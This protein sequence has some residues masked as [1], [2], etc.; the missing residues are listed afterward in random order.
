MIFIEF[1][2]FLG[3]GGEGEPAGGGRRRRR[4]ANLRTSQELGQNRQNPYRWNLFGE[5]KGKIGGAI[6]KFKSDFR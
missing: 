5:L 4:V 1:H 2:R 6:L 3:D